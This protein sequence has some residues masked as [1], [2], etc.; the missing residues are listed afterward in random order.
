MKSGWQKAPEELL[1]L[2]IR[3]LL[4]EKVDDRI[5]TPDDVVT[6]TTALLDEASFLLG[7]CYCK[8]YSKK[9]CTIIQI[10]LDGKFQ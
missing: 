3:W 4:Q 8:C 5:P 9:S 7:C 6:S 1:R 10:G 2:D